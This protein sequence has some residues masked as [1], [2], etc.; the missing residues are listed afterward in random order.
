[1]PD[2]AM[3]TASVSQVHL[4]DEFE[5]DIG[6]LESLGCKSSNANTILLF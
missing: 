2:I 5:L 3:A 4:H 6:A 1:M